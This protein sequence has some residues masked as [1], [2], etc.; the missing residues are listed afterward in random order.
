MKFT[1]A[2]IL[3]VL[4]IAI[5]FTLADESEDDK[6]HAKFTGFIGD[7]L[8]NC[9]QTDSKLDH[10]CVKE[11]GE[12]HG[13]SSPV[14]WFVNHAPFQKVI[15][16]LKQADTACRGNSEE[17]CA[18]QLAKLLTTI[19]TQSAGKS[20]PFA[21]PY[22]ADKLNQKLQKWIDRFVSSTLGQT[23]LGVV[24]SFVRVAKDLIVQVLSSFSFGQTILQYTSEYWNKLGGFLGQ[25]PKHTDEL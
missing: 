1:Y 22:V 9:V 6:P 2:C 19:G 5:A 12:S 21:G 20:V 8:N 11:R 14:V 10:K 23:A 3:L 13:I 24:G 25:A 17:N 18:V 15:L 7:L 4:L 16:P